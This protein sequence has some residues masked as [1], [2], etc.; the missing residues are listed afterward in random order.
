MPDGASATADDGAEQRAL[1]S[2]ERLVRGVRRRLVAWSGGITL[3]ILIVLGAVLY[4]AVSRSLA[5]GATAQL[6]DR[7]TDIGRS[8]DNPRPRLG[9][10][11][12]GGDT[13]GTYALLINPDGESVLPDRGVPPGLPHDASAAEARQTGRDVVATGSLGNAPIRVLSRPVQDRTGTFVI[14]V[15]QDRITEQRTLTI[16][17]IVLLIGGVVALLVASG[18]GA[19]YAS[20]ALVPIRQSLVGQRAALRRQREFAADASHELRTPLTVIRASAEHLTRHRDR[21]VGE[22]GDAVTDIHAEVEH[23][24]SLVDDLLLLARSDSGTVALA[25]EPVDLGDVAASAA[26]SLA[27]PATDRGVRVVV[28]PEPAAISGDPARLRQLVVILVDNAIRHTPSGGE[29]RV[30]VRADGTGAFLAVDDDGPGV[31]PEDMARIFERFWRAPGAPSGG[32]GLGLAIA[33][34]IVERHGGQIQVVNRPGGGARF[35]ARL[36]VGGTAG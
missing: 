10:G 19:F 2:D 7:A 1:E 3:L 8:I 35:T 30:A 14:Q 21:K 26:S 11:T 16:T 23:L 6:A 20:R 31:R 33:R 36:P 18:F 5:V 34:W 25:R 12:F 4:A 24:T 27:K 22:V 32:T 28:D 13:A 15:V 17:L 29:V 9:P